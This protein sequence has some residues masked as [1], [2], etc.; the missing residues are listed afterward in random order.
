MKGCTVCT[1][2]HGIDSSYSAAGSNRETT[3]ISAG[4]TP[5]HCT[6][7][8]SA[9]YSI[10]LSL[11]LLLPLRKSI[12]STVHT[13]HTVQK[14]IK[15]R[16]GGCTVLKTYRAYRA[17]YRARAMT[18]TTKYLYSKTI[19][20]EYFYSAAGSLT[21]WNKTFICNDLRTIHRILGSME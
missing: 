20:P 16:A 21:E 12:E 17:A 3:G 15:T 11:S 19:R 5:L 13:V 4:S 14:P 6:H 10:P 9:T 18:M 7:G 8:I 1:V 2:L